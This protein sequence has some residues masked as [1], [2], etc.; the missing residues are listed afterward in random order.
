MPYFLKCILKKC[1]RGKPT[2]LDLKCLSNKSLSNYNLQKYGGGLDSLTAY[3]IRR[4]N[5][6]TAVHGFEHSSAEE[7]W[8]AHVDGGLAEVSQANL[9]KWNSVFLLF[10]FIVMSQSRQI[11]M[12][13][14]KE[15]TRN[16]LYLGIII[17]MSSRSYGDIT[18]TF[19]LFPPIHKLILIFWFMLEIRSP[20]GGNSDF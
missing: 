19:K 18:E 4:F 15:G 10:T 17:P 7:E 12:K 5:H 3:E 16:R 8:Q 13:V 11:F 9:Q 2:I 14:G 20:F 1:K 6:Y